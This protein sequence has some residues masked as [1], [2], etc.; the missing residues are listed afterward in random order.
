M[1]NENWQRLRNLAVFKLWM[2]DR[3]LLRYW[4]LAVF[5]VVVILALTVR[6]VLFGA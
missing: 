1:T 6:K 4:P 2:T 5:I 3:Q